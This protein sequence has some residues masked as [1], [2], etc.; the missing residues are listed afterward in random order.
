MIRYIALKVGRAAFVVWAAFTLTFVLLF[1]LPADPVDLLFDPA[2][3]NSIPPEVRDQVAASY[4]FDQPVLVQYLDRLAHAL[5]GDFGTSVQSGRNVVDAILEVLP[6]TL[7]LAVAALAVAV[8]IGFTIALVATATKRDWLRNVLESLPSA[9][10]SIPVFMFGILLLQVFS[11]WLGWFPSFGDTGWQSL[12]LPVITLAIPV[13]GPIAQLLV[14]S[15]GDEFHAGYVTTSWAKGATRSR[16]IIGDV[17]RNASLPA[18]T[19]A[20]ITF[21][22]LIAGAVITETV[23][24]RPGLG[25][26]TQSAI[27]TLDVPLVQGIVVFVALSF[28]LINL[29]VDLVYPL[30]DPRLRAALTIRPLRAAD[31]AEAPA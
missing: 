2:E 7:I 1:V 13:S 16:I 23:F 5:R 12:V 31:T 21:G 17:F 22:S 15:F 14:R 18:L 19:I 28:A 26:L 25:R 30:L 4:G 3:L 9:S 20:G 11:F 8:A 29:I 6:S 27:N 24:A 10:V